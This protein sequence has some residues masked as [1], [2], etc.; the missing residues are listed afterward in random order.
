MDKPSMGR[1]ALT[2]FLS[3][4]G[5]KAGGVLAQ[6]WEALPITFSLWGRPGLCPG[7]GYGE[8]R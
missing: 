5:M 4:T 2:P 3:Q 1:G 8:N 7:E 6:L